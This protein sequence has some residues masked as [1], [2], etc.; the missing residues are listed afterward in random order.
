MKKIKTVLA[1]PYILSLIPF[2]LIILFFQKSFHRYL[3]VND[4]VEFSNKNNYTWF[5]DLNSDG[6]S[7]T[8]VATDQEN[9]TAIAISSEN[10][11][12]DQWNF[13]GNFNFISKKCLF[14]TG[15]KD[16][17]G[18]KEIYIF[19]LSADSILLHCISDLNNPVPSVRNRLIAVVGKGIKTPDPFII[20]AEMDALDNDTIKELIFGIGSGFSGYPRNVYAYFIAKDSLVESPE[21]AYFIWKIIQTDITGDGK[22]EIIP[23]GYATSNFGADKA[24]YHDYSSFLM[25][26]DQDLK[27]L[28]N[29]V[30]F[31]GQYSKLTPFVQKTARGNSLMML[32]NK[33][34]SE[35]NSTIYA[36]DAAGNISD[37]LL[38]PYYAVD[39][40]NTSVNNKNK[41]LIVLASKGLGLLDTTFRLI[42]FIPIAETFE[43]LQLDLDNDGKNEIITSEAGKISVFREGLTN[44][45]SL[46]LPLE[47]LNERIFSV[48]INRLSNAVLSIQ[49]EGKI[50]FLKYRQNP[51]YPYYYMSYAGIYLG[52]LAFALSIR[53]IQKN[54]LKKKYD[55]EKKISELQL[56]LIRNQLDPHFTLNVINSIIYSVEYSDRELA[57]E[58]L[59]K[60]ANLY[61]N[62]LLS[63]SSTQRSLAEELDFC[64]DYLSLEKMRFKEKFNFMISLPDDIDL[65]ILLPKLLIQLHV[66]NA[67]KHGLMPLKN[68]GLLDINLKNIERGLSI[69]II[70]NGVGRVSAGINNKKSTGKGLTTMNE[71]FTIYNKY[72]NE[73]VNSEIIDLYSPDGK[74]AGTKVII[75]I[76]S[77]RLTTQS[78]TIHI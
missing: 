74:P 40:H 3:L 29:P 41:F 51:G 24:K 33:A 35:I 26:L 17:N 64:R 14:I 22:K 12:I 49:S 32:F 67:I 68:G 6:T 19:T 2:L 56:A 8:I 59:R 45:V 54:Q 20:P 71:L 16:N 4:G 58:Q 38:L 48:K 46:I 73:K 65:N 39:C 15:D 30:E 10:G 42:K 31:K 78:A 1:S 21:S 5:E 70:D 9:T 44:G 11:I 47:N 60:F 61:R 34:S 55:T 13:R 52:I 53:N 62:L 27:F 18:T 28:Y 76:F 57:G 66:E 63:A 50:Y 43:L 69:E 7:E 36:S 37:S 75:S 77:D 23:Y 25:T 72:Y